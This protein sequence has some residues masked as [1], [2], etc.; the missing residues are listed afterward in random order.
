M[1]SV[2]I[3][4]FNAT[5]ESN[6]QLQHV[7]ARLREQTISQED[8]ER[9]VVVDERNHQ[10]AEH[11]RKIEPAAKVVATADAT[12]YGM[13][14]RGMKEAQGEVI[15]LLDS[16]CL[17]GKDWAREILATIAGGADVVAGKVRFPSGAPF[18]RTFALF[19]SGHLRNEKDGQTSCFNVSNV[20]LRRAVVREHP[21]DDRLTRFGGGILLGRR[22]RSLGYKILYNPAVAVVHN[23]KGLKKH[24]AVRFRTG[25]E[26]VKMCRLD[27]AGVLPD[28]K[29]LRLGILAP[30]A[31]ALRRI[32]FDWQSIVAKRRELEI[33]WYEVPFFAAASVVVRA[34]EA[35]AGLV[36]V[37][38]PD[39]FPRRF[40]R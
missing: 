29:F 35:G 40:G 24:I 6:I 8:L 14:R 3:E 19:D 31:F 9:I 32:T 26:A 17:P 38:K 21:F 33:A 36:S 28:T 34:A 23:D 20:A 13:K 12:Y 15:A 16:D 5:P 2:V 18:S 22:L 11:V 1:L 4:T 7:L 27:D 37:I 30:F 39:Y 10:L 25:H